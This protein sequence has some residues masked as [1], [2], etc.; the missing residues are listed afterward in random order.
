MATSRARD[1]AGGAMQ[2]LKGRIRESWG[3]RTG[4]RRAEHGGQADR[5]RGG[6]RNKKGHGKDIV[7]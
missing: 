6:A 2:Y 7:K 4:N 5:V 3:V 1:K